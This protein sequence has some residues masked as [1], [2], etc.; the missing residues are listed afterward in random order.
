MNEEKIEKF[1]KDLPF[2]IKYAKSEIE[3]ALKGVPITLR[4][5]ERRVLLNITLKRDRF[6]SIVYND[7]TG[8]PVRIQKPIHRLAIILAYKQLEE[9]G[10]IVI[11]R[12]ANVP[13]PMT[14]Y[15]TQFSMRR[16]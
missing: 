14:D 9:E 16:R 7:N 13:F 8:K 11:Q 2:E 1:K 4:E 6:G 12:P 5:L 3:R 10:K 15:A